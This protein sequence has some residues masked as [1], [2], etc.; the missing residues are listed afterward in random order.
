[1]TLDSAVVLV[2]GLP[3]GVIFAVHHRV[4]LAPGPALHPAVRS[5]TTP[6]AGGTIIRIERPRFS[7]VVSPCPPP[8]RK[9]SS[10]HG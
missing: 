7:N 10:I 9:E 6:C 4:L 5:A 2:T 3:L 1:M 8:E